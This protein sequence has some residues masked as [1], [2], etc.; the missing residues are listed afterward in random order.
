M[1]WCLAVTMRAMRLQKAKLHG[2]AVI[3]QALVSAGYVCVPKRFL[4]VWHHQ[5]LVDWERWRRRGSKAAMPSCSFPMS[6]HAGRARHRVPAVRRLQ[7]PTLLDPLHRHLECLL[8]ALA[9]RRRQV[10]HVVV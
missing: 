3:R 5:P 2:S 9:R 7:E 4:T 6:P 8:G 10:G 1:P